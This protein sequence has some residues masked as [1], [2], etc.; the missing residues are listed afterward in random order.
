MQASLRAGVRAF[1][2]ANALRGAG[3]LLH[4]KSH[5]TGS[6]TGPAGDAPLL[7][8]VNL[9]EAEPVEPAVNGPQGAQVLAEGA[10]HLHGQQDDFQ[11]DA[12]LPEEQPPAWLLRATFVL[13]KGI[14]PSK[15]P[16]GQRY[17]QNVGSLAKPPNKNMEPMH[18]RR[19]NTTY[20]PYFRTRWPG[21][22][23]FFLKSGIL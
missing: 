4:G 11:Q 12:Q 6:L 23:F 19:I 13:S 14:A 9:P 18:T 5:R 17:L 3:D 21:R 2:T 15:V 16:E 7:F 1:A 8:P 20:F 22:R 10:E